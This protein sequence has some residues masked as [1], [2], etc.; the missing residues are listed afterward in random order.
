VFVTDLSSSKF[1]RMLAGMRSSGA[2]ILRFPA[3]RVRPRTAAMVFEPM[4]EGEVLARAQAHLL[5][6]CLAA[7]VASLSVLELLGRLS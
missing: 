4:M 3:W 7:W 6:L 5:W 1:G 2:V